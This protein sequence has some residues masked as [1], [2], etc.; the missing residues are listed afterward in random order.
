MRVTRKEL[1]DLVWK[2]PIV[3]LAP[4]FG[5]SDVGLS[6][7]CR[8]YRIPMPG[9][10]Y[11]A[12]PAQARR[13]PA[14]LEGN[15][16]ETVEI[17]PYPTLN[18]KIKSTISETKQKHIEAVQRIGPIEV[19]KRLQKPHALTV[20]TQ[21]YMRGIVAKER[22]EERRPPRKGPDLDALRVFMS[23]DC[24]RYRC[25]PRNGFDMTVSLPQLDRALLLLDS[26]V[27][28]LE[29]QGF[30]IIA[31]KEPDGYGMRME[32]T[33][34]SEGVKFELVERYN[35]VPFEAAEL[36]ALG[37]E[38]LYAGKYKYVPNGRLTLKIEGRVAWT[39]RDWT[40]G[41]KRLE[42]LLPEIV[43]AFLDLIP[44]QKELRIEREREQKE[45][46]EREHQRWMEEMEQQKKLEEFHDV[47]KE[48]ELLNG[49]RQLERYLRI[50]ERQYEEQF[51][52]CDAKA[53]AWFKSIRDVA[54]E[55]NPLQHRL[56]AIRQANESEI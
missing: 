42:D 52:D 23:R 39:K 12:A 28:G 16:S 56:D 20:S 47:F 9:R 25:T 32:A 11:W 34:D 14:R 17:N 35:Q 19:P 51:G 53:I 10:G 36:N 54:T 38:R 24:G 31:S 43:V 8:R 50:L 37:E 22:R 1:Y 41:R 2:T 40:D 13:E 33:K 27:K 26:L 55:Q 6:K 48:S 44:R 30:A 15:G 5:I 49:L 29:E 18:A 21:E 3:H 7:V 45:A 46:A 4:S